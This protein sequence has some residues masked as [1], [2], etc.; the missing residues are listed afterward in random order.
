ME[1]R[2]GIADAVGYMC[3]KI[4]RGKH[5]IYRYDLLEESWHDTW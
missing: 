5:W 2:E 3:C 1:E 4:R